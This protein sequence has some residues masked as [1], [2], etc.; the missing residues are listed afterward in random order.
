MSYIY[1]LIK[2]TPG[3][4]AYWPLEDTTDH[5]GNGRPL[6]VD[7]GVLFGQPPLAEGL[8]P[9]IITPQ[10][11]ATLKV[12]TSSWPKI[13]AVEGRFRIAGP[14]AVQNSVVFGFSPLSTNINRCMLFY[15]ESIGLSFWQ[16]ISPPNG[17]TRYRSITNNW[18]NLS[19]GCHHFVIQL[20]A[21]GTGTDVYIDGFKDAGLGVPLDIFGNDSNQ[22]K[23]CLSIKAPITFSWSSTEREK[24]M[25]LRAN[26]LMRVLSVRLLRSIRW[27]NIFPVRCISLGTS[28]A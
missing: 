11:A 20:N 2:N 4:L 25:V 27:V 8:G 16:D 21:A 5:S 24:Q 1:D 19:F 12:A 6:T 13:R 22:L 7:G 14:K 15:H 9:S 3:L 17:G 23:W 28:L 18:D 26:R 10:G